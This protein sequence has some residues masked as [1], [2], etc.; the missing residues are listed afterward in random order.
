MNIKTPNQTSTLS[1]AATENIPGQLSP[2]TSTD[3]VASH[4][5]VAEFG[6]AV[7]LPIVPTELSS[8]TIHSS[9]V[10]LGQVY[11]KIS[12]SEIDTTN[13][14]LF[15][16]KPYDLEVYFY[17]TKPYKGTTDH[18][19]ALEIMLKPLSQ[20]RSS[21][22]SSPIFHYAPTSHSLPTSP[23]SRRLSKSKASFAKA[24]PPTRAQYVDAGTQWSPRLSSKMESAR[25]QSPRVKVERSQEPEASRAPTTVASVPPTPEKPL[26]KPESPGM[27]RRQSQDPPAPTNTASQT[28]PPKRSRS[29]QSEVRILP[30]RYE[31]CPVEDMVVLIANMIQE[32]IQTNDSLP[33][34]TGALTRFH[35]RTP[36]GISVLDYL[37]RL[38]KHAT[39]TPPLLLSMVYYIDRLCLLYPAFTINTLTVHRFLITAATVAAKGLSDSFW[40]N[41]TYARVGG[42]KIAELGL[43]ELDFLYRVDW[44]IVPNPEA[45]VEYYEGLIERSAGYELEETSSMDEDDDDDDSNELG[46]S[47]QVKTEVKSETDAQWNAW[48]NDVS[49]V[50]KEDEHE[51]R[52]KAQLPVMRIFAVLAALYASAIAAASDL[53]D[54]TT[55][56]IQPIDRISSPAPLAEIK[57]NPSTLSAELVSFD[58][59][60]I[61][62]EAKLLRVGVYDVATES[63]KSST[64]MTSAETFAKGYSPTLVLSLDA[65]GGIIGVSCKSGKI[66]A[67]Q[68]R[69]FGPKIKVLKTVKG[70]LPELNR[71]VVLSPEGKVAVPE[72]EKTLLQRY[73][74]VGLAVVMLLMTAGGGQE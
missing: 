64:S 29:D 61:S 15:A 9:R 45:L 7:T 20:N 47:P 19:S 48:M 17:T 46:D 56:Y 72:P 44:K 30:A 2:G 74:W 32:L 37:Q 42:I 39:L 41:S 24:T 57:Y 10:D 28:I 68:T 51:N 23:L 50:K 62:P 31:F 18:E 25:T 6:S 54:S 4:K 12:S 73:W 16:N 71:P 67:G 8:G 1:P 3:H 53:I 14:L 35:S 59:P 65:Q 21:P 55:V 26:I 27:K 70:K 38:A 22:A 58:A 33:P 63:W 11:V 66:D 49:N 34:R 5:C 69:D 36:P 13:T 43:L 40:N 60:E 52:E